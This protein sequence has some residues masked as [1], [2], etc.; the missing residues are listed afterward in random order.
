MPFRC[1]TTL[2]LL[3]IILIEASFG[4]CPSQFDST[5]ANKN[6]N[7][8][9]HDIN[10]KEGEQHSRRQF[11]SDIAKPILG[12]FI[13]GSA[14]TSA[15]ASVP[16]SRS[17]GYDVQL[18]DAEWKSKLTPRQYE[19]LREGGTERPYTSILEGE[20]RAG[21]YSCAGCGTEL[22][23]SES[24]FH[25]GTGWPSFATGLKGV[26][27]KQVSKFEAN[28]AGAE[29]R[30]ATCGG[31]LGDVFNDGWIFPGTPAYDSGKRF[32]V[33]GS[34][35]VFRPI[36]GDDIMDGF[37][38]RILVQQAHHSGYR[39]G[40][41]R[42]YCRGSRSNGLV[43]FGSDAE[44]DTLSSAEDKFAPHIAI[45]GGGIYFY[46]Q[47][48]VITFLREEGYDLS[49]CTYTGASAGALTATLGITNVD[50]YD[51][52]DL[53]L[54]LAGKAGVWDRKGGLQGIW[55][56]M[57]EEW[58]EGLI[59]SDSI[60]NL[61]GRLSLLGMLLLHWC[62]RGLNENGMLTPSLD[63]HPSTVTPIP[64]FGKEK[65]SDFKSKSDLVK[66]NMASVH[67]PWFLDGRLTCDF[68]DRPHID[69]SFLARP[70]DFLHPKRNENNDSLLILDWQEDPVLNSKGSFDFVE[71]L[72]PD[73][74]YGLLEYGKKH[75][76]RMEE[77]GRFA[78]LRKV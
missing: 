63:H 20:E 1:R 31:H 42:S 67:L 11:A 35:L 51:A 52:T 62:F 19:I 25:S 74:I 75:A 14:P 2:V 38:N 12:S 64:S 45:P 61:N 70:G 56:P 77:Q 29:I 40:D 65:I 72:S 28:L 78:S 32:C 6:N 44:L 54:S 13:I 49:K 55:G 10:Q 15:H 22:F 76:K 59:P 5:K 58:L 27:V 18:S 47:A 36:Q 7:I 73:G 21:K 8:N 26:E 24:K 71:A 17:E 46:W 4:L 34:A 41:S 60:E 33:D 3:A 68:R 43:G 50:F 9:V 39:R 23:T 30:C 57:V 69:G 48:G 66:C 53:A 37:H 16:K